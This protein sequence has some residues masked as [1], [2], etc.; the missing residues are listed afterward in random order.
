MACCGE[1]RSPYA[2]ISSGRRSQDIDLQSID[3]QLIAVNQL[4]NVLG[5]DIDAGA[6]RA[7]QV[8]IATFE[9]IG[10]TNLYALAVGVGT[11]VLVLL[12]KMS[13]RYSSRCS[14]CR[15]S[16]WGRALG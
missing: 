9:R 10:D 5:I 15:A 2:A 4:R 7:Y 13:K 8:L 1:T 14:R 16:S 12:P 3:G 6:T 11:G